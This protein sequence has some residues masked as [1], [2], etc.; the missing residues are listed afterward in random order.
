VLPTRTTRIIEPIILEDNVLIEK[1]KY[2]FTFIEQ[3]DLYDLM[4]FKDFLAEL[5]LTED[6][7]IQVIQSTHKQP[8]IFLK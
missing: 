8:T 5:N 6:A 1:S 3:R 2:L 4:S 7:Y